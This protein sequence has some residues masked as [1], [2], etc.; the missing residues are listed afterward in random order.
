M[1]KGLICI[2]IFPRY[3]EDGSDP[4]FFSVK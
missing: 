1:D 3:E 2:G 4:L